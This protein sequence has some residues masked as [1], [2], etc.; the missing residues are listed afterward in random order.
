MVELQLL[1]NVLNFGQGWSIKNVLVNQATKEVDIYLEYIDST[2]FYSEKESDCV[3]YDF[4][5]ARRI[6]HLDL[7]DYKSYLNFRTPR[8]KLSTGDIKVIP[9]SFSD[10]RVSFSFDFESKVIETLELS[11]NQSKT[12]QYLN[13]SF[14]IVHH[15]MERAVNRGVIRRS[16]DGLKTLS[17]D[18]KSYSNGHNYF[19]VLSDPTNKRV[20][21]IIEGRST[22]DTQELLQN[23]LTPKQLHNIS[24]VTMDMW[25]PYITCVSELLPEAD[26]V[27]DNFHIAKYLNKGVDEVRKSEV[28]E[29]EELKH[30]KY[31]LLK[32]KESWTESQKVKFQEIN[33]INLK[34]SEAWRMKENFKEIYSCWTPTNCLTF[35]KDWYT[36]VIE[37]EI[38]QMV[39]VADTL[40]RHLGGIINAAL[41]K[42]SNSMAE[43]LNSKI[44]IVKS[45]ARGYK[46]IRGYRNAILFFNGQLDLAPLKK[47]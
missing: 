34:T 44:Q 28:K 31:V 39:S 4:S 47:L 42:L 29:N 7:F 11:K 41:T 18:E 10:E 19:T 13:T 45:V 33:H 23:T 9:V 46:N 12:A 8:A 38:K 36:N 21:D 3:I 1:N 22:D 30:S 25:K 6:R 43:N 37:S 14:E 17:L 32:N 20:L 2:C 40:L 15:I 5:K 24:W 16:L 26:I 27:H 35:F